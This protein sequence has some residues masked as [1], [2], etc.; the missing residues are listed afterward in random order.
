MCRKPQRFSRS[1]I[2]GHTGRGLLAGEHLVRYAIFGDYRSA[3]ARKGNANFASGSGGRKNVQQGK[4]RVP[5]KLERSPS[6]G[7]PVSSTPWHVKW[8][9]RLPLRP[10][11]IEGDVAS[12]ETRSVT[13]AHA[14]SAARSVTL[15]SPFTS[16][17]ESSGWETRS[18]EGVSRI[19]GACLAR[20]DEG[21][22]T[23]CIRRDVKIREISLASITRWD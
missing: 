23:R 10:S 13:V 22:E 15:I 21:R 6:N 20:L 4:V 14:L 7:L 17:R 2:I 12:V 3:T 16:G 18:N 19:W 5:V 9:S 1:L 11:S 8:A